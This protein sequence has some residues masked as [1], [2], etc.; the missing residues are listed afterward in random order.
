VIASGVNVLVSSGRLPVGPG[1]GRYRAHVRFARYAVAAVFVLALALGMTPGVAGAHVCPVA[2]IIPVGQP[3]NVTVAVTVEAVPIP[4][5]QIDIPTGLQI[6]HAVPTPGWKITQSGQTL[7]YIG[8]NGTTIQPFTCA[9]FAVQLT[10]TAKG[11]YAIPVTQRDAK[12]TVI[13]HTAPG[14]DQKIN[15]YFI[16]TVYAGEKPPKPPG[17]KGIST[18]VLAGGG[19]IAFGVIM[20]GFLGFR[21][22]RD[23]RED[24]RE[25]EIDDRLEEFKRQAKDRAPTDTEQPH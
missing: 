4:D 3:A 23:R 25:A 14:G 10:A 16:Q 7:R 15:P 9:Y 17:G 8:Q 21:S 18:T 6:N 19:L 22:W 20:F 24:E 12:G 13:A 5:V 11:A 2:A 1:T